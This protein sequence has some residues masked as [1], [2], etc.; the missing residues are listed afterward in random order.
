MKMETKRK[1]YLTAYDSLL[2]V[3]EPEYNSSA[4]NTLYNTPN[5]LYAGLQF[6]HYY[7]SP[8]PLSGAKCQDRETQK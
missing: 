1:T 2:I 4:F 8:G 5:T 6:K 7:E 3:T